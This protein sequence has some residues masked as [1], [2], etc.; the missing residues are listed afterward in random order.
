[1]NSEAEVGVAWLISGGSV[2]LV[3][4]GGFWHGGMEDRSNSGARTVMGVISGA[5]NGSAK[6]CPKP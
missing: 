3:A 4:T 2:V 6:I 1:M 5:S